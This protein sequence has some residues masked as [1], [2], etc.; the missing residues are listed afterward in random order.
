MEIKEYQFNGE[1]AYGIFANDKQIGNVPKKDIAYVKEKF[2]SI[3]A[4][5]N[6]SVYG[7]GTARE[8]GE[9]ISFGAEITLNIKI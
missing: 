3:E 4:I 7:G 5:S 6:I 9:V 2:S 1:L 8:S